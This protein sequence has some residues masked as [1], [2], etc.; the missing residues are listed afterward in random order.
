MI[1]D[2]FVY[3]SKNFEIPGEEGRFKLCKA[4]IKKQLK[5]LEINRS[6]FIV[7]LFFKSLKNIKSEYDRMTKVKDFSYGSVLDNFGSNKFLAKLKN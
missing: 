3:Y 1:Y 2:Q 4:T 6:Y 7:T 5:M